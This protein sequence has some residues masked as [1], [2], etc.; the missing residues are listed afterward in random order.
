M[1]QRSPSSVLEASGEVINIQGCRQI[2]FKIQDETFTC[3]AAVTRGLIVDLV[4]GRDFAC[5]YG[6]VLDDEVGECRIGKLKI[7]L[8]SYSDIQP[9]RSRVRILHTASIPPRSEAFVLAKVEPINGGSRMSPGQ[10]FQG[11]LQPSEK[12]QASDLWVPRSVA[13]VRDDMIIPVKVVNTGTDEAKMLKHTDVGTLFTI[14]EG[15]DDLFAICEEAD[16]APSKSERS[17]AEVIQGLDLDSCDLSED[18]KR[19]LVELVRD[20]A[21]IFSNGPDDIGRTHRTQHKIK[22]GDAA[23]IKQRPRRI[24]LKLRDQVEQQKAEMIR[25]GVIEE[26][27]SPWCSPIVMVRKKD[28][29]Y[30]FCV[31]LRAV[32][33]V[34]QGMS[35]PLPRVDDALDSLA[36]AKYFSSLDMASGY[37]Q[38]EIA[39]EDKEKTAFTTGK[40]LHHFK[41]MAFGLKNAG[42]T[43]QKLMELIMAG[44]DNKTCLVYIDDIIVFNGTEKGHIE[45]LKEMFHRIRGAG[46]KLKPSK[47]L[48]G[49]KEVTF[50]GHKVMAGGILPDPRNVEKVVQ[51]PKPQNAEQLLSFLGLCGYYSKFVKD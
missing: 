38:V 20:F 17:S 45:T 4:L 26:S 40:G 47:C 43:F 27:T 13:I 41:V 31:D 46:M 50:L 16:R 6:S 12:K 22:T 3:K 44:M 10:N 23:S 35:H 51:W 19:E 15:G 14:S 18:G 32:N 36:G 39:P 9:S 21:D 1:D 28:G 8:P 42:P 33:S 34:T 29:N 25:D 24:S 5:R 11:V 49:R 2:E 7:P 48:L 37:W 30:R